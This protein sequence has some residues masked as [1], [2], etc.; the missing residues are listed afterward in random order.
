[1]ARTISLQETFS[2]LTRGLT[3][4]I[5]SYIVC[6]VKKRITMTLDP[7]IHHRAKQTAKR[8]GTTFSGLVADLLQQAIESRP[9]RGDGRKSFSSRW[10]GRGKLAGKSGARFEKL[11][12]KHGL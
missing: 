9:A 2:A 12:A 1:M 5:Q 11:R 8:R 6:I 7:A 10:T 3:Q 4:Y